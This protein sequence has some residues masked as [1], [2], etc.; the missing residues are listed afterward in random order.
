MKGSC[1]FFHESAPLTDTP[2]WELQ[3]LGVPLARCHSCA[4]HVLTTLCCTACQKPLTI[5]R[6]HAYLR[7]DK[8]QD[9]AVPSWH[10]V[11]PLPECKAWL[12][13]LRWT[14]VPEPLYGTTLDDYCKA[15]AS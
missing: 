8:G 12:G 2:C 13:A 5:V 10:V 7:D 6:A 4:A 9:T 14:C 15:G 11:H 3:A 1:S